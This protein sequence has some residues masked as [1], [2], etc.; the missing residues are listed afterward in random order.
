MLVGAVAAAGLAATAVTGP[1]LARLVDR[2]GQARVA[3]PAAVCAVPG[4]LALL[5]CV[6]HD[7]A[8]RTLFAAYAAGCRPALSACRT[9]PDNGRTAGSAPRGAKPPGPRSAGRART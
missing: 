1:L 9:A 3:V 5:P 7:A 6:R 4:S 2:H 8:S